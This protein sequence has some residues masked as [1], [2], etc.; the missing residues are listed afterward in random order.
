MFLCPIFI[1]KVAILMARKVRCVYCREH[2]R[3]GEFFKVQ[4]EGYENRFSYFCSESD[5]NKWSIEQQNKV[6]FKKLMEYVA[7]DIYGYEKG[8]IFP[9][10]LISRIA[11]L[12]EFYTYD[13]IKDAFI[14][15]YDS[16]KWALS[17][18]TFKN[19]FGKT[20][21]IMAIVESNINDVYLESKRKESQ[22]SKKVNIEESVDMELFNE[23]VLAPTHKSKGKDISEFLDD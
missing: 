23:E 20:S 9:T 19:E 2:G 22:K 10:S 11:K 4:K 1:E 17:N 13:I 6:K 21:Y 18:K 16:I 8:M 3:S 5:Y 15:S 14:H 12:H 7:E